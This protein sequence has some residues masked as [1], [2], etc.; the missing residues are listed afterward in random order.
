MQI[1]DYTEYRLGIGD[2]T[3]NN[4]FHYIP[5]GAKQFERKL[6]SITRGKDMTHNKAIR[7]LPDFGKICIVSLMEIGG[8]INIELRVSLRTSK[9]IRTVQI[10]P[11]TVTENYLM[12]WCRVVQRP[13]NKVA[14]VDIDYS[15][16]VG[17]EQY[18]VYLYTRNNVA[19]S[20][21]MRLNL[22]SLAV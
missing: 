12:P 4:P 5:V 6:T 22:F 15:H 18:R 7:S 2:W 16:G 17:G 9:V 8:I 13:T 10:P 3:P 14:L 1:I 21:R 19:L 11:K 20:S